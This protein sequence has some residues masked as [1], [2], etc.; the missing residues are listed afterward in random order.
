LVDKNLVMRKIAE[1][2]RYHGQIG[3]FAEIRLEEWRISTKPWM[4]QS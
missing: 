4:R 1:L 3:E 2:E